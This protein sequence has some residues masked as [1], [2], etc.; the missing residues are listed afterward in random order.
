MKKSQENEFIVGIMGEKNVG[1]TAIFNRICDNKF[2]QEYSPSTF[3]SLRI[4]VIQNAI[5]NIWDTGSENDFKG[6]KKLYSDGIDGIILVFD[7]TNSNTFM[8]LGKWLKEI[9]EYENLE[10][11]IIIIV[12]NKSDLKLKRQVQTETILEYFKKLKKVII[13]TSAKENKKIE[14]L[15]ATLIHKMKK[16]R[17]SNLQFF[18]TFQESSLKQKKVQ[19]NREEK[20]AY[21][22]GNT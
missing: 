21:I 6:R 1:K 19:Q 13:E 18:K 14:L 15:E 2:E 3:P 8:T 12:G 17:S 20:T 11:T 5:L 4:K 16:N 22:W 10:K 9:N 7:L